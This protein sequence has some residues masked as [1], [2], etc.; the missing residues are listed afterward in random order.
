MTNSPETIY[1]DD[2]IV[3]KFL[4]AMMIWAGV[5]FLLGLIVAL[6]LAYW[7]LNLGIEYITFGRLRPLHTNAAIFAFAGNAI[8]A[9]IY[10]SSQRLMKTRLFSDVLSRIHFWGWQLIILS[11]AMV[12]G[13]LSSATSSSTIASLT[14]SAS[15]STLF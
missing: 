5:A 14:T 7:P 8:F 1:Y 11:A 13:S 2:D 15:S 10:H 9:G 3:K 6:Q 4:L 12:A